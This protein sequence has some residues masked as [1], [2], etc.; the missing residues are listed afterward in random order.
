VNEKGLKPDI[1]VDDK[2][3]TTEDEQFNKALE[4]LKI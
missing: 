1:E 4:V 3:D 2:L